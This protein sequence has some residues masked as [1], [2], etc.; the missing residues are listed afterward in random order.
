MA[1]VRIQVNPADVL[2]AV[3]LL[4]GAIKNG[5]DPVTFAESARS[6]VPADILA[7]VKQLGVDAFLKSVAKLEDG[8]P[9]AT[10]GGRNFLRKVVKYL[11]DGT[12]E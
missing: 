9:L 1:P 6:M 4:E 8:S 10:M 5:T 12:T 7:A 11:S 2:I 3:N